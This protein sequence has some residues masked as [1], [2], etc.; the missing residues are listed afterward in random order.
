MTYTVSS[1]TLNLAQPNLAIHVNCTLADRHAGDISFTVC[2]SVFSLS[3]GYLVRD[4]F[5]AG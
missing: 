3:T 4:I 2:L 1:G 5:G